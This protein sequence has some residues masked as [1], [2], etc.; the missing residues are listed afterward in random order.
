MLG[1]FYTSIRCEAGVW[2]EVRHLSLPVS[3][4]DIKGPLDSANF[5]KTHSLLDDAY[6]YMFKDQDFYICPIFGSDVRFI[7]LQIESS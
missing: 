5:I 6:I 7:K 2:T 1:D 4:S 3:F